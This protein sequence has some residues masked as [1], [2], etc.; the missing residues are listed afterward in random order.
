MNCSLKFRK[1]LRLKRKGL[2]RRSKTETR[3]L[4]RSKKPVNKSSRIRMPLTK[5]LSVNTMTIGDN[6][7]SSKS[8]RL[9]VSKLLT[10]R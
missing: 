4:R 7:F 10:F 5:P 1:N 8:T 6:Y 2:R 9:K 3:K